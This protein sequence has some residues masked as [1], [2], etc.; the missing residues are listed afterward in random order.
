DCPSQRRSQRGIGQNPH[1]RYPR[2]SRFRPDGS[3]HPTSQAAGTTLHE[4]RPAPRRTCSKP[5]NSLYGFILYRHY[6]TAADTALDPQ[7]RKI[8]IDVLDHWK[9][10]LFVDLSH[11]L[12]PPRTPPSSCRSWG[13]GGGRKR[14]N[15]PP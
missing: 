12:H 4:H 11:P 10:A 7:T 15:S 3:A 2:S 13:K 1:E 9:T 14:C 5:R 8:V 6:L